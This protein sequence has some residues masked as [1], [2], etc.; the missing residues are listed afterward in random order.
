M[1]TA[2]N[3][4]TIQHF[5]PITLLERH[6]FFTNGATDGSDFSLK[7]AKTRGF[8]KLSYTGI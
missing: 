1:Y 8:N 7:I 4:Y 3:D 2:K 6:S 5:Y